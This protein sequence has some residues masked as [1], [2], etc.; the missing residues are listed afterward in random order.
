MRERSIGEIVALDFD[1]NA[2]GGLAVGEDWDEMLDAVD[3]RAKRMSD[4]NGGVRSAWSAHRW[5]RQLTGSL[6]TLL[7]RMPA[8]ALAELPWSPH[9]AAG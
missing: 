9:S 5:I 7:A 8:G 1:G 3:E 6:R 2:L 4:E